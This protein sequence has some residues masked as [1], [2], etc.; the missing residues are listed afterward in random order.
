M[1]IIFSD[2]LTQ[3]LWEIN[4]RIISVTIITITI[5][6]HRHMERNKHRANIGQ[7][8]NDKEDTKCAANTT[9]GA[10]SP[11][12][13]PI[14]SS[15][16]YFNIFNID[17]IELF[18][19]FPVFKF[20]SGPQINREDTS[21]VYQRFLLKIFYG[22]LFFS[23]GLSNFDWVICNWKF[24]RILDSNFNGLGNLLILWFDGVI[25]PSGLKWFC[26]F[27]F[28]Q[29]VIFWLNINLFLFWIFG[30]FAW[31]FG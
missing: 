1:L 12:W 19:I 4:V 7:N 13:V 20:L 2:S 18:D 24:C 31:S 28:F 10:G 26:N 17:V 8:P 21:V 9:I 30:V 5:K 22:K 6:V 14:F 3:Q 29:L 23:I 16:F 11:G 27:I 25:G 15:L